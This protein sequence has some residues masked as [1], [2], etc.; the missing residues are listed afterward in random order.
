MK[1]DSINLGHLEEHACPVAFSRLEFPILAISY[2]FTRSVKFSTKENY[3]ILPS[4]FDS[5]AYLFP[6]F[7]YNN[8]L[9]FSAMAHMLG[10]SCN[11]FQFFITNLKSV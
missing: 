1:E 6:F 9:E 5:S 7:P 2:H 3:L 11:G 8:N 4:F 10:K